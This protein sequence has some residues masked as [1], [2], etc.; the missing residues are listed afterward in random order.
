M[1][2]HVSREPLFTGGNHICIATLDLDRAVR[3]WW[4][5]YGVGP[6]RVYR[7]DPST[8]SA[9]IDGRPTDFSMQVA[10]A[11]MGPHFRVE[12]IQPLDGDNPYTPSLERHGG[13]DHIHHVR[14]DVSN[15]DD[16]VGELNNL[17]L[18]TVMDARFAG[19]TEGSPPLV[20]RYVDTT[21][22]LGFVLELA[23]APSGFVMAT[24]QYEYPPS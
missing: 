3:T 15:Y 24:P 20:G 12:I 16:A 5:R 9:D 18:R 10:L 14:F 2:R 13:A 22:D 23:H 4:D 6:W 7:Y 11:S 19:G 17:G 1:K 8:V 21:E